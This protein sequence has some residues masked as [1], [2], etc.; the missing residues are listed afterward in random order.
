MFFGQIAVQDSA[1]N[2]S[3]SGKEEST[4]KGSVRGSS[5]N[6]DFGMDDGIWNFGGGSGDELSGK[7]LE[8]DVKRSGRPYPKRFEWFPFLQPQIPCGS[9]C[10][11]IFGESVN[12]VLVKMKILHSCSV[13][14]EC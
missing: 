2:S 6:G 14:L 12:S 10:S 1:D 3:G 5:E 7:L 9:Y 13:T 4:H 8:G 11:V